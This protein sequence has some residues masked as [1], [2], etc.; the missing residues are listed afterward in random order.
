MN[1]SLI[2]RREPRVTAPIGEDDHVAG[3]GEAEQG[4]LPAT[5][6]LVVDESHGDHGHDAHGGEAQLVAGEERSCWPAMS[7]RVAKYTTVMP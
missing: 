5:P 1:G 7:L 3:H 2:Q 6:A 4:P